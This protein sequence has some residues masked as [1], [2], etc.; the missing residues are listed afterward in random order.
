MFHYER[1]KNHG[2][3]IGIAI[4]KQMPLVEQ[5]QNLLCELK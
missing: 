5:K 4:E 2:N 3:S 1:Y